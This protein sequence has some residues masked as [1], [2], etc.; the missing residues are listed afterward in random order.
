MGGTPLNP[1]CPAGGTAWTGSGQPRQR[2]NTPILCS[3]HARRARPPVLQTPTAQEPHSLHVRTDQEEQNA[4]E[5]LPSCHVV[6]RASK[7]C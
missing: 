3:H 4:P 5:P 2:H 7:R 1:G 6:E